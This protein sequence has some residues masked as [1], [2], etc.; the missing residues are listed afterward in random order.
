MNLALPLILAAA[1]A[2]DP[3]ASQRA[4]DVLAQA[5][6]ALGGARAAAVHGI[7]LEAELRRV[8]PVQG[9]EARDM[10]G[11]LAIDAQL[12]DRYLRV[13]SL[14]PM[15]GMPAF[16]IGTG[17]DGGEAW[18]APLGT[19]SGGPHMVVRVAGPE[20]PAATEAMLQRTRAEMLRLLLVALAAGPADDSLTLVHAGEAE[21]PEGRADR[22]EVSSAQ[23][24]VGTLFIDTKTHRPLMV[25]FKAAAQ[26]MNMV[27]ATSRE[28]AE[29]AQREAAQAAAAPPPQADAQLYVA[30]WKAVDGVL[31][32]HRVTQTI[33]GGASEEWTIRKWTLDPTFKADHFKRRR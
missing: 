10:S 29:R 8:Q 4:R 33:E 9:G 1:A 22:I 14:S 7:S 13:E 19:P 15:P 24:P 27:R 18:R 5:R 12:P 17:L 20:G 31:L 30:D 26:R 11:E 25:S 28:D 6:Q 2:A 32:P 23:G 16:T 3:A 21:A